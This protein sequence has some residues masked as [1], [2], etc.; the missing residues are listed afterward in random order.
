M[1]LLQLA[2]WL[3][4]L[5]R[6]MATQR[7]V[8]EYKR[9]DSQLTTY[10]LE[11]LDGSQRMSDDANW[12]YKILPEAEVNLM[13]EKGDKMESMMSNGVSLVLA[14]SNQS[15]LEMCRTFRD[16]MMGNN[17][18]WKSLAIF[19]GGIVNTLER[20]LREEDIEPYDD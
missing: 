6:N 10:M 9:T 4:T 7:W 12:M 17:D 14:A 20:H 13:N 18:A 3:N 2:S 8:R 11:I 19:V 15:A 16:A 5:Q 1:T